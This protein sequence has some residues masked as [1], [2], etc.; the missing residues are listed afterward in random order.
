MV[1]A[2][3]LPAVERLELDTHGGLRISKDRTS[4]FISAS[5]TSRALDWLKQR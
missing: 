3:T 1:S 4:L 2:L 5:E